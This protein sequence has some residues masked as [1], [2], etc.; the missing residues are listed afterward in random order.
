MS[1]RLKQ[2]RKPALFVAIGRAKA[3]LL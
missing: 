3:V 2:G 1:L